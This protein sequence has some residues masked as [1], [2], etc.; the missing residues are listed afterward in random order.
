MCIAVRS[1]LSESVEHLCESKLVS[2]GQGNCEALNSVVVVD[3][4]AIITVT[5][6]SEHVA[7]V[8]VVLTKSKSKSSV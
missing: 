3:E 5:N 1:Y 2:P 7:C 8:S 4:I 6:N